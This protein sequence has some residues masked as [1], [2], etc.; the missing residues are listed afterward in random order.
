[1]QA[2]PENKD[3]DNILPRGGCT[4]YKVANNIYIFG[5]FYNTLENYLKF[6]VDI[7]VMQL[8]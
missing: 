5:G 4:C 8:K 2:L 7:T 6:Q 3:Y 1:M